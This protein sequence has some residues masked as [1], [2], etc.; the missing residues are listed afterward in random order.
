MYLAVLLTSF[1]FFPTFLR[2]VSMSEVLVTKTI[3]CCLWLT[4]WARRLNQ[5]PN[6]MRGSIE[7]APIAPL[8]QRNEICG[9][10]AWKSSDSKSSTCASEFLC[11]SQNCVS[12]LHA[13]RVYVLSV[14]PTRTRKPSD[15]TFKVKISF[16]CATFPRL[17][18]EI[19][20]CSCK[21]CT[22]TTISG[23]KNI[24]HSNFFVQFLFVCCFFFLVFVFYL[25]EGYFVNFM[26]PFLHAVLHWFQ[27]FLI[28]AG[29]IHM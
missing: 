22:G 10:R 8:H 26:L 25:G 5:R 17:F 4:N 1:C 16:S 7:L 20:S 12:S 24:L 9:P 23:T 19:L 3:W 2:D 13:L 21:S 14:F 18:P 27:F 15:L 28:F 6:L 11:I 29:Y